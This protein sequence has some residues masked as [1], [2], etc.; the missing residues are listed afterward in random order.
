MKKVKESDKFE[1]YVFAT[2]MH[3]LQKYGYTYREVEKDGFKKYIY[4]KSSSSNHMDIAPSNTIIGFI[5]YCDEL[6][7]D[8][9]VVHDDRLE[10]LAGAIVGAFNNIR[11]I[12]I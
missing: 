8:M 6:S 1:L 3:M 5:N 9:I 7:P 2:G 10:V 12:C 11:V 4:Q